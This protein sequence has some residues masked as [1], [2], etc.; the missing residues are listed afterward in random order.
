[1]HG[2]WGKRHRE[3]RGKQEALKAVLHVSTQPAGAETVEAAGWKDFWPSWREPK[4]QVNVKW[5]SSRI[6]NKSTQMWC[7]GGKYRL[8]PWEP[9]SEGEGE[10]HRWQRGGLSQ[11]RWRV[12]PGRR[13]FLHLVGSHMEEYPVFSLPCHRE[14]SELLF[15]FWLFPLFIIS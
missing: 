5:G 3:G 1:M 15:G 7:R 10:T 12:D 6:G 13:S 9:V 11:L 4:A 14:S 8:I 2:T